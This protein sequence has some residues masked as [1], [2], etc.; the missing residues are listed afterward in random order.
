MVTEKTGDMFESEAEALVNTVNC[1]GVMGR[2]VAL[3]FKLRY[4]DNYVAY[5]KACDQGLVRPGKV[6]VFDRGSDACPRWII[7]FPTKRHWRGAS[8]IEDIQSGLDDLVHQIRALGIKS[9][10]LPP[11]GCGLG[12]LKWSEVGPLIKEHLA[13]LGEVKALVYAPAAGIP[14]NVHNTSVHKLTVSSASIILLAKRYLDGL[15]DPMLSLLEVQKLMYFLQESGERLKL[16]YKKDRY[17]PYA[18]NLRFVLQ[19]MEGHYTYGYY[20]GGDNPR[21]QISLIPGAAQEA[22]KFMSAHAET[23]ERINRVYELTEGFESLNGMELLA[24][25]HWA[26]VHENKRDDQVLID[27]IHNWTDKKQRFTAR[28]ILL[29]RKSLSE[30]GWFA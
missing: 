17:G 11:L 8:R 20:D 9:I 10:V 22:G 12:G 3:Q 18:G 5:K 28:Q 26:W 21:K 2:G 15:L 7:N 1:V 4:P 25:V 6:F 16:D 13:A 27:Y 24:S 23:M 29:A 14:R 30:K 19:N